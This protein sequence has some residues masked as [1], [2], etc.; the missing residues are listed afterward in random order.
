MGFIRRNLQQWDEAVQFFARAQARARASNDLVLVV[1]ARNE[2]GNVLQM[3]GR[4]QEALPLHQAALE[5]A[6][7]LG[8]P[9]VLGSCANDLGASLY[10]LGRYEEALGYFLEAYEVHRRLG[11]AREVALGAANIA[12]LHQAR[13]RL[14]E[15]TA[16]A[17]KALRTVLPTQRPPD[18]EAVRRA[19]ADILAARERYAEAYRELGR[20]YELRRIVASNEGARRVADLTA[21]YEAEKRQAEIAILTRDRAIQALELDREKGRRRLVLGG[22]AGSCGVLVLL[23]VGYRAKVRANR[24]ITRTNA[25]LAAARDELDR[26][27]RTDPLTGLANRRHVE[28]QLAQEVARFE[29]SGSG[30]AVV[31]AD[32]DDFKRVNDEHWHPAG[33]AVLVHVAE[34]IRTTLRSL[35][36]AGRWGGEEIILVL[37]M[38]DLEGACHL[39]E[40]VRQRLAASPVAFRDAT[41]AVSATFGVAAYVGGDVARTLRQADEAL[42]RG[43][44]AGKNRVEAAPPT[45][46]G[47]VG[48]VPV[49]GDGAA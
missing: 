20:A 14:E 10:K 35:D 13:G 6:R 7:Q 33:D 12:S 25:A 42:Y 24:I 18:E 34:V 11:S 29:R 3:R 39:A 30:F 38:T 28:E 40:K 8:D 49:H 17:E 44:H 47:A 21:F 36:T 41:L 4:P 19:L 5:L 2:Q 31:M 23:A 9:V 15:A 27:S 43:K 16:W 1:R 48:A 32:L 46:T 37:P 26:L 22:L 45:S